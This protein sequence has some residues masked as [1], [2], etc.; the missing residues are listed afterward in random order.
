M[1]P[2]AH[3]GTETWMDQPEWSALCKL[4][5][6]QL[7]YLLVKFLY[8]MITHLPVRIQPWKNEWNPASSATVVISSFTASCTLMAF[9]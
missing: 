9:A 3:A 2:N 6:G 8:N 7:A 1:H 4:P 5:W